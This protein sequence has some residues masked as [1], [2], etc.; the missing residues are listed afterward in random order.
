MK[1]RKILLTI[2]ESILEKRFLDFGLNP[3][4]CLPQN[5]FYLKIKFLSMFLLKRFFFF[6]NII[7]I[8]DISK[9]CRLF[10][11][12]QLSLYENK[13]RNGFINK[14]LDIKFLGLHSC[15]YFNVTLIHS[16]HLWKSTSV[17]LQGVNKPFN[18]NY[19]DQKKVKWTF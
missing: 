13:K 2:L 8:S 15:F 16:K 6:T 14:N 4:K 9:I 1:I 11:K 12:D 3:G 17:A 7:F 18:G 10:L 19:I 5:Q